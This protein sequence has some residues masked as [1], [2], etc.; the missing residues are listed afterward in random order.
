[1]CCGTAFFRYYTAHTSSATRE[2][3]RR[4]IFFISLLSFASI[5]YAQD[6]A[7]TSIPASTPT[8]KPSI[9]VVVC[10]DGKREAF[11]ECDDGNTADGDGCSHLCFVPGGSESFRNSN[12]FMVPRITALVGLAGIVRYALLSGVLPR[13]PSKGELIVGLSVSGVIF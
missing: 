7:P 11:E 2:H 8:T 6:S 9:K 1:M 5:I 3:M 4:F 10:G 12:P 13:E